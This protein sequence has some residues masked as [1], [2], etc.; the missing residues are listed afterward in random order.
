MNVLVTGI[1][2]LGRSALF[3]G[4]GPEVNLFD[5]GQEMEEIARERGVPYSERNI[6]RAN[7]ATLSALRAAAVERIVSRIRLPENRDRVNLIS[8]HSIFMMRDGFREG[9]RA[10]DVKAIAPSSVVTLIDGPQRVHDRLRTHPGEYF[11]LSVESIVRWQEFEVFF[12]GHLA[13]QFDAR[14]YVVPVNQRETFRALLMDREKR[15]VYASYPMTHLPAEDQPLIRRFVDLLSA[16]FTVFDPASI[17]GSHSLRSYYTSA[18]LRSIASHTVVRDLD[19]FIGV[20][21]D[22][23]VA[24]WPT[25]VFS[26]GMND[27]LRY[28]YESGKETI[29]VTERPKD[30]MLPS[31]SPFTTYKS[32]LFWSSDDFAAYLGL[33]PE[34]QEVYAWIQEEVVDVMRLQKE[35]GTPTTKEM[36]RETCAAVCRYNLPEERFGELKARIDGLAG[37]VYEAWAPLMASMEKGM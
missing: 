6:L 22:A 12:S 36:F 17:E 27:E 37:G 25:V 1:S 31:L 15:V 18:D 5:V 20:N 11:H 3:E 4:L 28:A 35:T 2:G 8:V 10:A 32:K 34:L 33:S 24:Y 23:V 13:M 19:W 29:L 16:H 9:L 14:H 30:R 26:S 7:P 21:A